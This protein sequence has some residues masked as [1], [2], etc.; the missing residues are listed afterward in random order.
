MRNSWN[1]AI[2][3]ARREDEGPRLRRRCETFD[4]LPSA[5]HGLRGRLLQEAFFYF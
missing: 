3:W 5:K 2:V 4:V 1:V